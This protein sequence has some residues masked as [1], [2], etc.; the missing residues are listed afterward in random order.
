[1]PLGIDR[2]PPRS[3]LRRDSANA[4]RLVIL[5]ASNRAAPA[6]DVDIAHDCASIMKV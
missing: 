6:V 2:R 4:Q 5:H 3:G 1:M